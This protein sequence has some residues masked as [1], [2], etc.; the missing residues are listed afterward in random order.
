MNSINFI[1]E[2]KRFPLSTQVLDFLQNIIK[3][4]YRFSVALGT[5]NIIL[6]GCE[7][8]GA[9]TYASGYVVIAGELLPFMGGVGTDTST[10]RIRE[11]KSNIVA[12]YDTYTEALV[13]RY[14]E[15]GNNVG[16]LDTYL[17]S[18]FVRTKSI[19]E[20]VSTFATKAELDAVRLLVMP[21]GAIIDYDII[22]NPL[23]LPV[24]WRLCNGDFVEGYGTLPDRRGRVTIGFDSA[25]NNTPVNV[26]DEREEN[27]KVKQNYGA[28]GNRGGKNEVL[29]TKQE[30]GLPDFQ[31]D[32]GY[33]SFVNGSGSLQEGWIPDDPSA[34]FFRQVSGKSAEKTHENRMP[35]VVGYHIIKIV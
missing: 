33:N 6:S 26:I 5:G 25:S 35:Y 12:E 3:L 34:H 13:N 28:V 32:L 30:S 27:G 16:G 14:V 29:L 10:V 2:K 20:I 4:P 19:A 21:R 15:F 22:N 18:S 11:V 24:G 8:Q 1:N 31:V 23:P 7:L 9:N 17:W